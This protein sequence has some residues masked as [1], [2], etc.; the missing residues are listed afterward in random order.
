MGDRFV[1]RNGWLFFKGVI[2][3]VIHSGGWLLFKS[4]NGG[5][6]SQDRER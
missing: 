6:V 1:E 5:G 4:F 3:V 2:A